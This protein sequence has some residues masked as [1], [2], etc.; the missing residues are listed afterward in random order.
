MPLE[1]KST[2]DVTGVIIMGLT[3][4][5]ALLAFSIILYRACTWAKDVMTKGKPCTDVPDVGS[6]FGKFGGDT[7]DQYQS[8]AVLMAGMSGVAIVVIVGVSLKKGFSDV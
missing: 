3:L 4:A 1:F 8:A 6:G 2:F 7:I 5:S